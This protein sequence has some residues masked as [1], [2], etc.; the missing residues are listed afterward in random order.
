MSKPCGRFGL[1]KIAIK[2]FKTYTWINVKMC[3]VF[4]CLTFLVCLFTSYNSALGTKNDEIRRTAISS[5]YVAYSSEVNKKISAGTTEKAQKT[6][7]GSEWTEFKR[8]SVAQMIF[9]VTKKSVASAMPKYVDFTFDGQLAEPIDD[10]E[11]FNVYSSA[12][13]FFDE[14]YTELNARFGENEF[15]LGRKPQSD[16]EI[17]LSE[18]LLKNFNL[19]RDAVG[20][21]VQMQ[22]KGASSPFFEGKIVGII[23]SNYYNLYG[24]ISWSQILP[25]TMIWE[26]S[27]LFNSDSL[28][29]RIT[30]LDDY[31][32]EE[33]AKQA[34]AQG[35]T[36]G[37]L[38]I[39]NAM[40]MLDN[41][42]VLGNTL[43]II[44]GSSLTVGLILTIVL[45]VGKY[46]RIF[47]R[48]SGIYMTFGM[49]RSQMNKLLILQL[50]LLALVS[51]P[52]AFILTVAGYYVIGTAIS[53]VTHMTMDTSWRR[54]I[55]M[56]IAG[57]SVIVAITIIFFV[58][59]AAKLRKKS[60]KQLLVT[61]ISK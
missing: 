17:V 18:N 21:T 14:D 30:M 16:G 39:V 13:P 46:V 22:I 4:A 54:I 24:H 53:L 41:I 36:Y 3:F 51:I 9:S 59:T 35:F 32:S 37:A 19:T 49:Q 56:L 23:T 26:G 6:F 43:Y 29:T 2:N 5:N 45:M 60:I 8:L 11:K 40:K 61:N 28:I 10:A 20:S 12:F 52:I 1:L 50:L 31:L 57:M 38:E 47:A 34:R 44:I 42:M 7:S 55:A 27:K 48:A 25:V 33:A 15:L 58:L